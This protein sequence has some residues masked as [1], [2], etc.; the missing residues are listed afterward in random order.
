MRV[1][2]RFNV[3]VSLYKNIQARL[4]INNK[5]LEDVAR[6][7]Q[8][9]A[10]TIKTIISNKFHRN[11]KSTPLDRKVFDYFTDNIQGF[12]QYCKENNIKLLDS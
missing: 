4:M 6:E 3:N 5:E 10:A 2:P 8:T 12:K 11:G 1:N 9:T 7:L